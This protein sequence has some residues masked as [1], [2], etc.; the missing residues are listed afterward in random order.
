MTDES[1]AGRWRATG[2]CNRASTHIQAP[3]GALVQEV[4]GCAATVQ[5][6]AGRVQRVLS[7]T[8][9]TREKNTNSTLGSSC[10]NSNG[11]Q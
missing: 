10:I 7:K 4:P 11:D 9:D 3:V 1:A 5:G 8:R 2:A 6:D